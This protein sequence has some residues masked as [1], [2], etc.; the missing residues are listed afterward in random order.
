MHT[1]PPALALEETSPPGRPSRRTEAALFLLLLAGTTLVCFYDLSGGAGFDPPDAWVAQTAREMSESTDWRGYVVPRFSGETRLQKSP[2]PYWAVLLASRGLGRPV[3]EFTARLPTAVL[4]VGLV[5]VIYWLARQVAGARAALFA[6]FAAASSLMLLYWSHRAAADLGVTTFIALSL[7][8]LWTGSERHPPGRA[9]VALWM[10]GYFAAGLAMLYK[11]PMPLVCVGLPA[12]LYVL[13]CRRWSIL[14]S[15]WHLLGAALFLLPWLPWVTAA[16]LAEPVAWDKWRVEFLDRFTGDSPNVEDQQRDWKLYALYLGVVAVFVLP[17]TLSLPAAIWRAIRGEAL[18]RP[19]DDAPVASA[20][21]D[22]AAARGRWFMLIWFVGLLAFFTAA[23]GK[24]TRYIV[25]ALPPMF[26]LVGSELSRFFDPRRRARAALE[27][28]GAAAVTVLAPL[29]ALLALWL[30][31]GVSLR[32]AE[33]GVYRWEQVRPAVL[34]TAAIIVSGLVLTAWLRAARREHAAFAALVGT[35]WCTW[36]WA[37]PNLMPIFSGQ[38]AFRDFAQQLRTLPPE[39]RPALRQV[40]QQDPRITWYSDVRFPRVVDQLDLLRTQQ[41]HRD[42]RREI[43]I[44]GR[45][46]VAGLASSEPALFVAAPGDFA[47]FQALA[48]ARLAAGDE[49]LPPLHVWMVARVGRPDQRYILFGNRPPPWPEPALHP[50]VLERV[51]RLR[52]KTDSWAAPSIT[53]RGRT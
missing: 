10:V 7:A 53:G 26:V 37:W 5:A 27:R 4:A 17:Y 28:F 33:F 32:A 51:A 8:A 41:G 2:G 45:Q 46:I 24:E 19:G 42:L 39:L 18:P 40:A 23:A 43:E 16:L 44:V 38:E 35:M 48:P 30:L 11:M 1:R 20:A 3:D 34:V 29:G 47:L 31:H 14:A 49:P 22:P 52:Q 13:L 25:P 50:L 6:G 36:L 12:A 9:R 15:P 21:G